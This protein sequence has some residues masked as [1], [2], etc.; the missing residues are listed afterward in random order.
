MNDPYKVLGVSPDASDE[1][2]KQAYRKL[3]K[4]YHPDLNPGDEEAARHMQ[5]INVAY[6]Q[7]QNPQKSGPQQSSGGYG[8][9]QNPYGSYGPFGGFDPFEEY[10]RQAQ[11][12]QAKDQY[13]QAAEQYIRFRKYEEAVNALKNCQVHDAQWYYL[14]AIA[15]NGLGHQV[16]AS[17]HIKKAVSMDPDNGEYLRAMEIIEQGGDAYRQQAGNYGG[18]TM[19]GDPCGNLCLCY[20]CNV[21]CCPRGFFCC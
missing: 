4:K 21:L 15:H 19:G 17:E 18:F 13:Q 1:E 10:R 3:A 16:T 8:G 12:Q 9:Y 5:E 2:I 20:L 6:D 11:Q 7:L 14:S